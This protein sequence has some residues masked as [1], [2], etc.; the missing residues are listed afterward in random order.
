MGDYREIMIGLRWMTVTPRISENLERSVG[1]R[2]ND[3]ELKGGH[4]Y[5]GSVM[6]FRR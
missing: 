1:I 6:Q 3:S 4:I 2:V 5:S